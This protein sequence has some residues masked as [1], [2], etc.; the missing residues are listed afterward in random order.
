MTT[1]QA[2]EKNG[3]NQVFPLV[4]VIITNYNYGRFLR[5]SIESVFQQTY[6]NFEIIVVDDGST[7][8]SRDIIE[9]YGDRLIA[10][11]QENAGMSASRNAGYAKST[12]EIV[13]FLDADDYYHPEKLQKVV[14]SFLSHPE[15]VMV[16]HRWTCVNG[17]SV[18]VGS[19][20]SDRMSRGDVKPLLLKWGKYASAITSASAYR[21][22]ALEKV[23]PSR[24]NMGIDTYL[25][26]SLPFYGEVG[27]INENLMFY[28]I[29][30]KNIRAH[31]D[32]ID[33]LIK[34]REAIANFI[35]QSAE[36]QGLT[37]RFDLQ[38]DADYRTYKAIEK[39]GASWSELLAIIWLSIREAIAIRRSP[40]D[41][42]IRLLSRTISA[43]PGQ[44]ILVLR[45]GLRGYISYKFS[46]KQ[47]KYSN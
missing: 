33:R 46:S 38:R 28:R 31:S 43:V 9:S 34:Q 42:L 24:G 22:N 37:A 27:G 16:G 21:R 7:D 40:K 26:A 2:S 15:W 20:A 32:N 3:Y 36:N 29:H 17:E 5:Q 23:M 19:S 25:N 45:Y 41:T 39:G 8:N 44:G 30:G 35:N 11:F 12:G 14:S 13:C 4:S 18:P 10:V 47:P 1:L 6:R